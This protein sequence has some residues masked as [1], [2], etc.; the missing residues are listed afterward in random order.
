MLTP[1]SVA[2]LVAATFVLP[3]VYAAYVYSPGQYPSARETVVEGHTVYAVISAELCVRPPD[4]QTIVGCGV[5]T[6]R[7]TSERSEDKRYNV[8]VQRLGTA[9]AVL[10]R[11][12]VKEVQPPP[13]VRCATNRDLVVS[14][15]LENPGVL[16]F[17]D[18]FLVGD[19]LDVL[20]ADVDAN[21]DICTKKASIALSPANTWR[22]PCGGWVWATQA[23]NPDPRLTPFLW[24]YEES[25]YITDP[26]DHTWI[27][28]KYAPLPVGFTWGPLPAD[29]LNLQD[30]DAPYSIDHMREPHDPTNNRDEGVLPTSATPGSRVPWDPLT[31]PDDDP[32]RGYYDGDDPYDGDFRFVFGSYTTGA[33]IQYYLG[34]YNLWVVPVLYGTTGTT[35]PG[36]TSGSS[37]AAYD[38]TAPRDPQYHAAASPP[39]AAPQVKYNAVL[40]F[41][42]EDLVPKGL[43]QH[44]KQDL[45]Y[46]A[47]GGQAGNAPAAD[48]ADVSYCEVGTE[49]DCAPHDDDQEGNSHPYNDESPNSGPGHMHPTAQVDLYYHNAPPPPV[50]KRIYAIH[51]PVGSAQP[52]HVHDPARMYDDRVRVD[53]CRDQDTHREAWTYYAASD[54]SVTET[55]HTNTTTED[56]REG[57]GESGTDGVNQD[58]CTSDGYGGGTTGSPDEYYGGGEPT[59]P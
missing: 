56:F 20:E 47:T 39:F 58:D 27:V 4:D 16:W 8:T 6:N 23:G 21:V 29:P 17:N 51:D 7:R 5:S 46:N 36:A 50:P 11:D 59:F 28:D 45:L 13:S 22:Y 2:V 14:L 32:Y 12:R 19:D 10:V 18:Q 30:D 33:A 24:N 25:Y 3:S 31:G 41:F 42:Y 48:D 34:F 26:N 57:E 54:G 43:K 1:R 9:V 52:N 38:D 35:D 55:S 53:E 49:W 40:F 15:L 44:G 37:C